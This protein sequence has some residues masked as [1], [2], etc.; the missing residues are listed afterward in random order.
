MKTAKAFWDREPAAFVALV[1]S[2]IALGTA[3]GLQLSGEQVGAIMAFITVVAGFVTRAKVSPVD[4][5][6]MYVKR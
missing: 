6:A 1:S 4:N 3:F 2:A 5:G